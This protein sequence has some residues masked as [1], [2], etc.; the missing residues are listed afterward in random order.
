MKKLLTSARILVPLLLGWAGMA[1]G[2]SLGSAAAEVWMGRPLEMTVPARFAAG[3]TGG[4]CVQADV[5]YGENR[6]PGDRVQATV[7]GTEAQKRI[8]IEAMAVVNEPVVTVSVRAGC[9]NTITRNYT[10]LPEMPSETMVA[11]LVARQQAAAR[12]PVADAP[13]RMATSTAPVPPRRA[14]PAAAPALRTAQAPVRMKEPAAAT[15]TARA[16]RPDAPGSGPRLRLEP[17]DLEREAG[18]RVSAQLAQPAGDPAQRAAAAMLWRAINADPQ[19][20]LRT[21]AMLQKL[22]ADLARLRQSD[23]GTRAEV[24]ALRKR[25]DEA[26]QPWYLSAATLQVLGLLVLGAALVTATLWVRSR[27]A[28]AEPWYD[29]SGVTPPPEEAAASVPR[30]PEAGERAPL[31]PRKP[32]APVVAAAAQAQAEDI[33]FEL[34]ASREARQADGVL[35]V[36]TLAA[37]FEEVEFLSSLGLPHDAMDVLK[38]YLQDSA[39]PAPLAWFEL[40]RLC[41]QHEDP[42][43]VATVR[44]RYA[45][46]YG[47]D[48]PQLDRL[49]SPLGVES[50][51]ELGARITAAWGGPEALA[52][53]EEALFKVPQP[54]TAF[55]LQAGRD[56]L[57]LHQLALGLAGEGAGP[58]SAAGAADGLPLAPWAHAQDAAGAQAAVQAAGDAEGGSA[59]GIDIDVGAAP[60]AL[61]ESRCE[62]DVTP[63]L[64]E[65][66]AAAAREAAAREAAR[67]AQEEEAFSAAVAGE[68]V[69]ASRF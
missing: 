63:L 35:R 27:R 36:E 62:P 43:A 25:L 47:T 12:G 60:R 49:A 31:V 53:I 20:V 33:D 23:A 21:S 30:A 2:Q 46:H 48:A 67:K 17:I 34:P 19:E 56:L 40:M 38:A 18:L 9:R 4:E 13:L 61:P 10:L 57:S 65:M 15:R 66:Q 68:R 55:T 22:E 6:V 24:A 14:A 5:F 26:R 69:P 64:A 3:D 11:A 32:A 50:L 44:R 51:P 58:A 7:V 45:H 1:S 59:F 29:V 16:F 52:V 39:A 42:A 28:A 41:Q 54:G 8:R 37:T